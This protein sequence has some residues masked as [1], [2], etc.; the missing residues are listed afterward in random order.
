MPRTVPPYRVLLFS[1]LC[2]R[3]RWPKNMMNA[4]SGSALYSQRRKV[5]QGANK[6]KARTT[7]EKHTVE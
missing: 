7:K 3:A 2:W 5:E 4:D 6:C 1:R